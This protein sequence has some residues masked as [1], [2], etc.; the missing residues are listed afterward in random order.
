M[1]TEQIQCT[2][3]AAAALTVADVRRYKALSVTA[4]DGQATTANN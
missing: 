1:A 3:Q 2:M 4:T